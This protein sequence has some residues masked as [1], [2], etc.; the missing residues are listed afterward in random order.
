VSMCLYVPLCCNNMLCFGMSKMF[1]MCMQ[2]PPTT[3]DE[4]FQNIF[5]YIDWLFKLVR[6]RKLLFLAIDGVA[7]RAKMNQQRSRRFRT[8]KDAEIAEAEEERLRKEFE[9]EGKKVLPKQKLE[10]SD[11]NVITPGTEFM[12]KLSNALEVYIC[13]RLKSD[14]GW[15]SIKVILSDANSPGEG[16]HKIMKFI[17]L[18]RNHDGYNP[19][20]R[21]CLYGLDADL[22][23]L[24]LATH[25]I[26]FTILRED[27]IMEQTRGSMGRPLQSCLSNVT[28][29]S[30]PLSEECS[31]KWKPANVSRKPYQKP[32]QFLNIWT[33]REYLALELE[34]SS[35]PFKI[36]FER[37]IDD[38]VF[39][40]F[41]TGNDFLPHMPSLEI[42]EVYCHA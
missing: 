15:K 16:E 9:R 17:R 18:Q 29:A 40:C 5:E 30:S 36:D 8:A 26:H 13:L 35:P 25:E 31:N 11:S 4:V 14:I 41:F 38:F 37:I 32:Y 23:M 34:I 33:V 28:S 39:I 1:F 7:P 12:E 27:V 20:T 24:A 42:R 21:H 19:N 10:V 3:F 2:E 22:I 6:P